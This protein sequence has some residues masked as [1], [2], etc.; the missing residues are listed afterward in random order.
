MAHC[1]TLRH[2]T[3]RRNLPSILTAG[4]DPK[5][6]K[7]ARPEVWL[8]S[9]C[10]TAWAILHAAQR[11]QVSTDDIAIITVRVPRQWLVRRR[12]CVW[13]VNCRIPSALILS[14]NP[15]AALAEANVA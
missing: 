12:R 14:V 15:R 1:I 9:A 6:H 7:C 10:R 5:Y 11:H 2:A 8:H 13:T 4:I 3:P